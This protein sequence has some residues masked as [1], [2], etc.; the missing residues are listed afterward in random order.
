MEAGMDAK[1]N[2]VIDRF[3]VRL[4]LLVVGFGVWLAISY[5]VLAA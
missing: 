2:D 3:A 4:A 1:W 5:G